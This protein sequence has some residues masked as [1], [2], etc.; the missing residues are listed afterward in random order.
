[1][2]LALTTV[3]ILAARALRKLGVAAVAAASLPANTDLAAPGDIVTQALR[4]LGVN[5]V[6]A[7]VSS[8]SAVTVTVT[9]LAA[10]ALRAVGVNQ[11]SDADAGNPS[12]TVAADDI[13]ARALRSLGYNPVAQSDME[14][15]VTS[16]HTLTQIATIAL[17]QLQINL[18]GAVGGDGTVFTLTDVANKALIFLNIYADDETPSSQDLG[19]ALAWA[20]SFHNSMQAI[21]IANWGDSAIPVAVMNNYAIAVANQIA[22]SFEKSMDPGAMQSA[23]AAIKLM[24][25]NGLDAAAFALE[26]AGEVQQ[27]LVGKNMAS[28]GSGAIP[29]PVV[30]YYITLTKQIMAGTFE[31]PFDPAAYNGAM[32]GIRRFVL[33]GPN[34][35]AIALDKVTV[36]HEELEGLNLTTWAFTAIPVYVAE[37]YASLATRA[38]ALIY[39]KDDARINILTAEA[40]AAMQMMKTFA[41]SGSYGQAIAEAKILNVHEA[42][43]AQNLVAWPS[44]AIPQA[45]ADSYI[46]AAA[47]ML[48]PSVGKEIPASEY[49]AAFSGMRQIVLGGAY[50]VAIAT[51]ELTQIQDELEG[52]STITWDIDHI[53]VSVADSYSTLLAM[54]LAPVWAKGEGDMRAVQA[55]KDQITVFTLLTASQAMAEQV[56]RGVHAEW[57]ARGM[58]R[59]E[60]IDIPR[61]MEEPYVMATACRLGPQYSSKLFPSSQFD[62]KWEQMAEMQVWR[63]VSL[64]PTGQRVVAEYF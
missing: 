22:P 31:Q 19:L 33:S 6:A 40:D 54:N 52:S 55:A 11:I 3:P 35:Q 50:A 43:N 37:A 13:A 10:Q 18:A 4:D 21:G 49:A 59:W 17:Q 62:P 64:R 41:L 42:L 61:E 14:T 60:I 16:T 51:T 63:M 46:M 45:A 58:T 56:L 12:S 36:V 1:M 27:M 7:E 38:L 53:P 44:T 26:Q 39:E 28:W 8:P 32:A 25:L 30:P 5:P 57:R 34:G 15:T 23:V 48:A 9:Q 24:A 2:V 47:S 29:D 20:T